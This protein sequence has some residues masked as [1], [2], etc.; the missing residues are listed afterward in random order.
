MLLIKND[1]TKDPHKRFLGDKRGVGGVKQ[2]LP[3][4]VSEG[5]LIHAVLLSEINTDFLDLY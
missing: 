1:D 3:Y 2:S 4:M 5:T